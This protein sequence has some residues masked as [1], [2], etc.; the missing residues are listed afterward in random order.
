LLESHKH[1]RVTGAA[2]THFNE[3]R[4]AG[5]LFGRLH[6]LGDRKAAAIAEV[7]RPA[8]MAVCQPIEGADMGARE[9]AYVHKSRMQVPSGVG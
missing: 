4:A 9:V 1:G 2:R 7:D 8:G 6:H 5:H 3:H